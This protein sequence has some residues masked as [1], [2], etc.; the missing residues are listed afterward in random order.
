MPKS[1]KMTL[2]PL[3]RRLN[4]CF[5]EFRNLMLSNEY[6]LLYKINH[7]TYPAMMSTPHILQTVYINGLTSDRKEDLFDNFVLDENLLTELFSKDPFD[8]SSAAIK[9]TS[10]VI[11]PMNKRL[12]IEIIA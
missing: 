8:A 4:D 7:Y 10:N 9:E 2:S 6:M 11:V 5:P 1:N 12:F 3:L